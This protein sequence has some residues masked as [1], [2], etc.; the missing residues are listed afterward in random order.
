MTSVSFDLLQTTVTLAQAYQMDIFN[1][2]KQDVDD[3][4][5]ILNY[6]IDAGD[7][8]AAASPA[9]APKSTG[10]RELDDFWKYV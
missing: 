4:I 2:L 5:L 9:P 8:G 7:Q 1:I 10:K 6:F 3:V